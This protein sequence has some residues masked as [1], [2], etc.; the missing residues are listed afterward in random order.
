LLREVGIVFRRE[1]RAGVRGFLRW[2]VPVTVIVVLVCAL[3]PSLATGPLAAKIESLPPA[4]RA[5][6][7]VTIVDFHRPAAYLATNFIHVVLTTAILGGLWG[8][9]VVAREETLHTAELLFALPVSRAKILVGKAAAAIVYTLGLPVVLALAAMAVLGGV[10]DRPLEPGRIAALFA[11]VATVGA[12]FVGLGML[13]ATLVRDK[14]GAAGLALAVVLGTWFAGV[15]A[16]IAEPAAPLRWLS[17][18]KLLEPLAILDGGLPPHRVAALLA[19]G[20]AA[21]AAAIARYRR[22]DIHA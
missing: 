12:C 16:A 22:A 11:G 4:L 14:R 2:V 1:L 19:I 6:F 20:V 15:I 10:A 18:Y 21:G 17:P 3:Q 7:G 5:A 8:A 9:A 13:A